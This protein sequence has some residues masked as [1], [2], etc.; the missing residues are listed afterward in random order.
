MTNQVK[1]VGGGLVLRAFSRFLGVALAISSTGLWVMQS[2]PV[3]DDTVLLTMKIGLT[4]LFVGLGGLLYLL[5]QS[6]GVASTHVDLRNREVRRGRIASGNTFQT[7]VVVPF[8]DVTGLL[9]SCSKSTGGLANSRQATLY[10]RLDDG[11]MN[12][13]AVEVLSGPEQLLR[14][15]QDR[16]LRDL[17]DDRGGLTIPSYESHRSTAPSHGAVGRAFRAA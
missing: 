12:L 1:A 15:I 16:L 6:T 13:T 14:P 17:K 10:L 8:D 4:C 5:G 2:A 3:L 11:D 7:E 9:L